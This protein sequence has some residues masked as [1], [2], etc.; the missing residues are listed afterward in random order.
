MHEGD[1]PAGPKLQDLHY[2]EQKLDILE[3]TL[4][5]FIGNSR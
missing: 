1:I 4:Y 2:T 5:G 3:G